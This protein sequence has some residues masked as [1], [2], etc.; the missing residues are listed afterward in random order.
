MEH[1]AINWTEGDTRAIRAEL[2]RVLASPPFAQ[3]QRHRRFL[4]Y[5]VEETLAGHGEQIKGYTIGVEVF[6]RPSA[7]DPIVDPIVRVEAARLRGK[8]LE[9]YHCDGN[10]DPVVIELPKGAY[11]VTV[12]FR[13]TAT[14]ESV[15]APPG[16]AELEERPSIA[17]LPFVN[18]SADPKQEYFADGI[19]EDLITDLSKLSGL[20]VIC[21][22]SAFVYK[23]VSKRAEEIGEALGVRYLVGGSVRRH[24]G[25]LRITAQLVDSSSG[26]DVWAERY[27]REAKEILE[28]Q[29]DVTHSIVRAL[30]I[31]LTPLEAERLGHEGTTS[32]EAHDWLLRGIE[33]FWLYT[34]EGCAEAGAAFQRSVDLDPNYAAAHAWLARSEIFPWIMNWELDVEKTV[35]PALAHAERAVALDDLLPYA[36]YML[37]WVHLWRKNTDKAIGECRRACALDPN[38]AEA[39]LFLSL[40][41]S[42]TGDAAE[43]LRYIEIAMQLNPHP[44]PLYLFAVGQCHF[45]AEDYERAVAAFRKG[46]DLNPLFKPNHVYLAVIY[47]LQ[48]RDEEARAE[49]KWVLQNSQA[50]GSRPVASMFTAAPVAE[51]FG[52]GMRRAGLWTGEKQ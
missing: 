9:Y 28:I 6:G 42:A 44:G 5:L 16:V 7:F 12:H 23:G 33:R 43:A 29:D 36:H 37:G 52:S 8:L 10:R 35:V 26:R 31:R 2:E 20:F 22:Q 21:R 40:T 4:E 34:P 48:D 32:I 3:S 1:Q 18:V 51:R 46:I 41:L 19:T 47:A 25:R 50:V 30:Q 15:G 14:A 17:V 11:A 39:H 49:A 27:D 13:D 24:G 38:S 45:V